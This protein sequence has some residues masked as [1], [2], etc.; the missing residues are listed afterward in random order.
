MRV[1]WSA[2]PRGRVL[3]RGPLA[4]PRRRRLKR[5]SGRA[6]AAGAP[7]VDAATQAISRR[8]AA[9]HHFGS[10]ERCDGGVPA[11][12]AGRRGRGRKRE[13]ALLR[14]CRALVAGVVVAVLAVAPSIAQQLLLHALPR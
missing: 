2:V 5:P 6:S 12:V 7:G 11:P 3:G 8:S 14:T 13:T 4:R 10:H 9:K 1:L